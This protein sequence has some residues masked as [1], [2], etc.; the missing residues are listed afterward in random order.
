[1]EH[2]FTAGT[3][4]ALAE[5][6][7]WA[8][9]NDSD[10]IE[11]PALLMGLLVESEC[12]AAMLLAR[13]GIGGES[14]RGRWPELARREGDLAEIEPASLTFSMDVRASLAAAAEILANLPQPLPLATEHVL[15]GLVASEGEV[16]EWLQE[17]GL[18]QKEL[19][20]EIHRLYGHQPGALPL[21]LDDSR[22][23]LARKRVS[24]FAPRKTATFA[25]RKATMRD[26]LIARSLA[27]GLVR[28]ER[29]SGG[30][31]AQDSSDSISLLRVFD[32]AVNRGREGLRVVEDYAR[33][34]LDDRHLTA[35]LKRLRHDLVALVSAI[36]IDRRLAARET[37]A[38]VGTD[39]QTPSE[40]T[41]RHT[42]DI[43]WAN[44]TRL[45]EALR[46]LEEFG[47]LLDLDMAAGLEQL[48]YRTYT[49]HRAL[50][51]TRTSCRRLAGARLYVL[52]DGRPSLAEFETTARSLVESGVHVI[53]LRDKRLDDRRLIERARRLRKLTSGTDTLFIMNDRPDLAALARADGV[54]VGQ[55]E[56]TVKDARTIVGPDALVGVSTH[57]LEQAEAAVLDGANYIGVG[58]TFASGTKQF[59]V[60][61]GVELLRAVAGRIR[62]PAFAI[63]GIDR[64]NLP[65]VLAAGIR[66]VAV[67]GAILSAQDP[68]ASARRLLDL[69]HG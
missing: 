25:E 7:G 43:L 48:R 51:I 60:F 6:A 13:H 15:L 52:L 32:A 55:E 16:S 69:L 36:P 3:T 35:R 62:L 38:D 40:Q 45:E 9:R 20:T 59:D 64:Q 8:R 63:G 33:F 65:D 2:Q 18:D 66:R 10:E 17:Q 27:G 5:A 42:A 67:S 57:S 41:R 54:H 19:E 49:L 58:P 53:Q 37:Q 31:A 68:A 4:R 29:T 24:P 39:V 1:M 30:H 14:I 44:F 50:E 56:L 46:S 61:P 34:V 47:K 21:D 23:G 26:L 12:R 28:R 22:L 11:G